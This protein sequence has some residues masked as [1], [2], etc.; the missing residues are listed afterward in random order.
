MPVGPAAEPGGMPNLLNDRSGERT[1]FQQVSGLMPAYDLR[2]DFVMAYGITDADLAHLKGWADAG[3][4]LHLMT[5]VAWGNYQDYLDGKF[6]GRPHHDEGQ[7]DS[8]GKPIL[9]GTAVPYMVPSIA[10]SRFLEERLKKAVDA[11]VEAIHLEEPEF[12]A[13]GGFS[14]AFQRE[15]QI[16]YGEPWQRPDSSPDAQYRAS[17]LKYYLY[18]RTLDRLCGSLKEYALV[19]HQRPVRFYVPTHSLLNY[20]QWGIVSPESSLIDVPAV[21]GYIAQIWT[22]TARSPNTY[23]GRTAERTFEMG[24]LEYGIMQELVRGSSRRMWFLHDPIED[25]PKHDWSDY[26]TNYIRTLVASLLHPEIWRYEVAPWP[27]RVFQGKYP[28]GSPTPEAIPPEYA[29]TLAVVFNQLNDLEQREVSWERGTEGVGV[30]LADSA[31]F[32]RAQPAYSVGMA[33]DPH[34]PL[35]PTHAE[36]ERWS[37]FFGLAMP[38]VKHGVP[39]RPVQLDNVLRVPGYL[40]GYRT[41][42][43]SYEYMKPMHPGLHAALV[44]WVQRGGTLIYV[45]A[46]TDPFHQAHDWWNQSARP[47]A[48][49][50]EHL[51]ELLGQGRQPTEG[52]YTCGKGHLIVERKHPA[53]FSRSA[54]TADRLRTLV[55]RGVELAGET[56]VERNYFSLRR[57]PY[58][59]A[60]TLDESISDE[61]LRLKGR[62]VDLLDAALPIRT[63]VV[64]A[65]GQQAWLLDLDRVTAAAPVMLA[66]AGRVERWQ[67]DDHALSYTLATPEG[68]QAVARL[69]LPTQPKTVTIAGQPVSDALWD[70]ASGTLLV[71]HP[72]N[73]KGVEVTVAW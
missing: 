69:S 52:E 24:F 43:L 17:K 26:R 64:L 59:I 11:G 62:L 71:R 68:V 32:Q 1:G 38:L 60:A 57:G 33:A 55:R 13:H 8:A 22:G 4:G 37:A 18:R 49:P 61:P 46:D 63:E 3:Y 5:G 41:L 14:Q 34:D 70:A 65:P 31:M 23:Q 20:T 19:K 25:D 53:Y 66:A 15:W 16:F 67:P 28:V 42:L 36:V 72:G 50:S 45:G 10:F 39:V 56:L 44:D 6:D 48:A 51:C 29:T 40:D 7:V 21:D 35:R 73:P 27:S 9:H 2:S 12:W 54:E 47:Y 30:L 58:L